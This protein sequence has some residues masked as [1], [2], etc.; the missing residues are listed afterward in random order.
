MS[1]HRNKPLPAPGGSLTSRTIKL[2]TYEALV[3]LGN[4]TQSWSESRRSDRFGRTVRF[5]ARRKKI[6][7]DNA[8]I[9]ELLALAAGC[10]LIEDEVSREGI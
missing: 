10:R 7:A 4:G 6:T 9:M 8:Y 1:L 5:E 3:A 2:P